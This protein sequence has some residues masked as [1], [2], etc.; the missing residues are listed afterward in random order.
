[1]SMPSKPV[2]QQFWSTSFY[3]L[4]WAEHGSEAPEIIRY[5]YELKEKQ[6]TNIASGIASGAKPPE[7]LYESDFDL[8][9]RQ[10]AG[11]QKLK[12][13]ITHGVRQAVSHVNRSE[14]EPARLL[15]EI[16]DSWF[17][18]TNDGGFHDAHFHGGCSWCGIYYLQVGQAGQRT[19]SSAPNGGN[20]FYSPLWSGGGYKD[21]GNK[22]LDFSYVDPPIADGLL[23]LFPSYLLHSALPYRGD[24]DR[25][26]ISFNTRTTTAGERQN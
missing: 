3:A 24:K 22:Y 23:L 15:V 20:R 25:I 11:L 14:L 4:P 7:G 9:D 8:L 5:L 26:V 19:E 6:G 18:I 12:G 2:V 10:H 13:F 17:H 21:Y 1:M 16:T